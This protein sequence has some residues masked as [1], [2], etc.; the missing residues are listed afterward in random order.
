[1]QITE[2]PSMNT[3]NGEDLFIAHNVLFKINCGWQLY[4]NNFS[5][6]FL[7]S[8]Y[9]YP[10]ETVVIFT[11]LLP[12]H[13]RVLKLFSSFFLTSFVKELS[14]NIFGRI[15]VPL[16]KYLKRSVTYRQTK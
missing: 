8:L 14:Y 7:K 5:L 2:L 9:H 15:F 12:L 1:M 3:I 4:G 16:K 13:C 10:K 11:M 6:Q